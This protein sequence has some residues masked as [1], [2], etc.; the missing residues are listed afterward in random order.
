MSEHTRP[1]NAGPVTL[2]NVFEIPAEQIDAFITGWA[3]RAR[4][5]STHPGFRDSRLHRALSPEGRFQLVNVAHWDSAESYAAAQTDPEFQASRARVAREAP[6]AMAN[7]LLY[8]VV[9]GYAI[10]PRAAEPLPVEQG[11]AR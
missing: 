11:P 2:I 9:A 8:R 6:G 10:P 4:I 3:E 1:A 5:M 7:P